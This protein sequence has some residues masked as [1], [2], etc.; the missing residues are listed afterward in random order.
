[1]LKNKKNAK[2]EYAERL[3]A[4]R[5]KAEVSQENLAK[6]I[7]VHQPY[8]A[9]IESGS[10]SIGIDKQE[11][12]AS[13]FGVKYYNLADPEYPL[14]SKQ[15]LRESIINYVKSA[16]IET[17]YLD[18]ETPGF[19]KH[20]D[21]LLQTDFLANFKTAKEIAQEC[22]ERYDLKI[23]ATRVSDILSRA[24]RKK[25]LEI[26]K[27]STGSKINIYRLKRP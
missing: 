16:N 22:L 23:A 4:F 12:I 24:A 19:S 8:I 11:E 26:S 6:A 9:A 5:K 10:L 27:P 1:M 20:I 25:L 7:A 15:E 13:F 3:K 14:P 18:D 2:Q 17:G 21:E